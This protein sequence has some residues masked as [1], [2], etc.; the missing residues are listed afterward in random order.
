MAGPDDVVYMTTLS[1]AQRGQ[2]QT[3]GVCCVYHCPHLF[4]THDAFLHLSLYV[5][6][7]AGVTGGWPAQ[8]SFSDFILLVSAPHHLRGARPFSYIAK[9]L[10]RF[11]TLVD[12]EVALCASMMQTLSTVELVV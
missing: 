8:A 4:R 1:L 10:R 2:N 6:L 12:R 3:L 7:S 9:R 5:D 11:L